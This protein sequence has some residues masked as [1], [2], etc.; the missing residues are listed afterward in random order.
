[1]K[2][3]GAIDIKLNFCI[4][5]KIKEINIYMSYFEFKKNAKDWN[6]SNFILFSTY[7]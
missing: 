1:M 2:N 6:K 5:I 4:N 3:D 7:L